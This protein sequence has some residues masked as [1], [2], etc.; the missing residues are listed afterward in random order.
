MIWA[1]TETANEPN[2]ANDKGTLNTAS[3]LFSFNYMMPPTTTLKAF[4]REWKCMKV[5]FELGKEL[6][7]FAK[8]KVILNNMF[9]TVLSFPGNC[10]SK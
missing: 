5:Y 10:S 8:I 9:Q 2:V 7:A 1:Q 6:A 4:C 3:F